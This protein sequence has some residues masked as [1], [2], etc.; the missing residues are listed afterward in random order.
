MLLTNLNNKLLLQ[1][2]QVIGEEEFQ[3]SLLKDKINFKWKKE[4]N[5]MI[6]ESRA[7]QR[8]LIH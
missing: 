3:K 1:R 2:L 5:K 4:D 6:K 7:E 8:V